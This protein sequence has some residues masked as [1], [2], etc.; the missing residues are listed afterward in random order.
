MFH[1][2]RSVWRLII[3]SSDGRL[4][5]WLSRLGGIPTPK[6]RYSSKHSPAWNWYLY[7]QTDVRIFL[8]SL[9]PYLRVKKKKAVFALSHIKQHGV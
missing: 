1:K 3:T 9:L 4:I 5:S 6:K 8:Q 7:R 2:Q